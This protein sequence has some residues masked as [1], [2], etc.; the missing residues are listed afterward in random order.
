MLSRL[1]F[2]LKRCYILRVD[3]ISFFVKFEKFPV[4]IGQNNNE[5]YNMTII[6]ILVTNLE[7]RLTEKITFKGC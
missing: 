7:L 4:N 2:A 6:R 3:K 1:S 5:N